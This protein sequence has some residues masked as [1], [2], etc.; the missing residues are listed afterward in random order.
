[1][2]DGRGD[3]KNEIRS[4]LQKKRLSAADRRVLELLLDKLYVQI[5]LELE[6]R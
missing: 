5:E 2:T 1:M 6:A 4:I 3:L